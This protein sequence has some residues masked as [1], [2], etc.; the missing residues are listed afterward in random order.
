MKKISFK[1]F[2][3]KNKEQFKYLTVDQGREFYL[4]IHSY[5]KAH[6]YLK[7]KQLRIPRQR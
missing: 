2:W 6:E 5:Q 4:A 7:E 1:H 3:K